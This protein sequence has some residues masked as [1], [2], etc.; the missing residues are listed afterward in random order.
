[1]NGE[2]TAFYRPANFRWSEGTYAMVSNLHIGV[3]ETRWEEKSSYSIRPFFECLS[4]L[5][6]SGIDGFLY[7]RFA[8]K[9]AFNDTIS[10]VIEKP[11]VQFLYIAAHADKQGILAANCDKISRTEIR[12]DIC[13]L[14]N[15]PGTTL[16]GLFVG[17]CKFVTA[18]SAKFMLSDYGKKKNPLKWIAG[19]DTAADWVQST[20]LDYMFWYALFWEKQQTSSH[21]KAIKV[22]AADL[23]DNCEGLITSLGFHIYSKKKGP[24]GG[25]KDLLAPVYERG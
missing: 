17:S 7:E 6:G 23:M 4:L 5:N 18:K 2:L 20:A 12:N 11:R 22:V 21:H 15:K 19:Y 10:Y 3:I 9:R 13:A 25:V 16:H 8:S 24:G 14:H 1:M